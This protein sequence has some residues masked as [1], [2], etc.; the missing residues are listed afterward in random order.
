MPNKKNTIKP[1]FNVYPSIAVFSFNIVELEKIAKDKKI[2]ENTRRK[3][4][5]KAKQIRDV[6]AARKKSDKK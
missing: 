5:Q 2:D 1:S 6:E 4:E 3:V